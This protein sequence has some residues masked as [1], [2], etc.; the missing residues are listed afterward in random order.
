[1]RNCSLKG[2]IRPQ[3]ADRVSC[4]SDWQ[5]TALPVGGTD[6]YGR[7]VQ[8][9]KARVFILAAT[10]GSLIAFF[11]AVNADDSANPGFTGVFSDCGIDRNGDGYF[12]QLVVS[13]EIDIDSTI[14]AAVVGWL[15]AQDGNTV[16]LRPGMDYALPLSRADLVSDAGKT[17]FHIFFSGEDIRNSRTDGPYKAAL[18]LGYDGSFRDTVMYETSAYYHTAFKETPAGMWDHVYD[19]IQSLLR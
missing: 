19:W 3:Q 1:M 13:G 5:L 10:F 14:D 4:V 15:S 11:S 7:R 17:V 2:P 8:L 6:R 12:E 18:I 9:N 16:A